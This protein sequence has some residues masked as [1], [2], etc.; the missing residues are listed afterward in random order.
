MAVED[1]WTPD[2]RAQVDRNLPV[3]GRNPPG[4]NLPDIFDRLRA[5]VDNEISAVGSPDAVDVDY[6]DSGTGLGAD[7]QTAIDTLFTGINAAAFLA[8]E[9]NTP[10]TF[11]DT[12]FVDSDLSVVATAQ[13]SGTLLLVGHYNAHKDS[14]GGIVAFLAQLTSNGTPIANSLGEGHT[15]NSSDGANVLIVTVVSGVSP[16]DVLRL[17]WRVNTGGVEA[18]DRGLLAVRLG[19]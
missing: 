9:T 4:V 10:T 14:G 7:V 18:I 13:V 11:T 17:Q 15:H 1:P 16:G 8:D 2:E 3:M 5:N 6:D 19:A 12:A